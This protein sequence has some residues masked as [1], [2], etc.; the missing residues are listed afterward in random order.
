MPKQ[1]EKRKREKSGIDATCWWS[2]ANEKT[3]GSAREKKVTGT[4]ISFH[5]RLP[6][7]F[8]QIQSHWFLRSLFS[9]VCWLLML[10]RNENNFVT[11][12]KAFVTNKET[13]I[14]QT[15]PNEN[16]SKFITNEKTFAINVLPFS[17]RKFLL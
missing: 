3:S 1:R 5:V 17:K 2:A 14:L 8:F 10:L 16:L 11:T 9:Q 12:K 15:S 6:M 13:R 7:G 4:R